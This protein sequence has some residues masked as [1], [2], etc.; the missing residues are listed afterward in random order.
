MPEQWVNTTYWIVFDPKVRGRVWGVM[1]GIHD[2]P[3]PKMWARGSVAEFTGGV[4]RSEDGGRTW[5]TSSDG[6][7]PAAATHILLDARSPV[8]ARV[9]YVAALGRGVYKSSD[10]GGHWSLESGGIAGREPFAWR[11]VQDVNGVLYLVVARR[12]DDGSIGGAGDGALYRSGDSAEHW[13]KILLPADCNGPSGLAVDPRNPQRFYLAAW[14]RRQQGHFTGGGIFLS[15]DGG[16][17]WR[18]VLT[19]DQHIYDVTVDPCDPGRL[20]ACGFGSSAWRSVD[21]G[22]SWKRISGFNF[23]WGHRVIS[24]PADPEEIYI[25]TYGGGVWHGPAESDSGP[26]EDVLPKS[27]E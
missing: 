25:T 18:H 22:E 7:P 8:D 23:K 19:Q 1:S 27:G 14:G 4:C 21:G 12:S 26:V 13:T 2:L 9:L 3:R 15:T 6:M 16:G 17:A 20:Y 5:R 10:G 11:L 24:D